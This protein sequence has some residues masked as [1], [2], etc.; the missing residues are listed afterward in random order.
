MTEPSIAMSAAWYA[1]QAVLG[2]AVSRPEMLGTGDALLNATEFADVQ[3][4]LL[5]NAIVE[6]QPA[7]DRPGGQAG[8]DLAPAAIGQV[9]NN[10][11][12]LGVEARRGISTDV[13]DLNQV[14]VEAVKAAPTNFYEIAVY[15]RIV[16]EAAGRR[17]LEVL[18]L[19]A[20]PSD[21]VTAADA[22]YSSPTA[23]EVADRKRA[24]SNMYK[25]ARPA[26]D[27]V[28]PTTPLPA[29]LVVRQERVL[30][31]AVLTDAKVR[32]QGLLEVFQPEDFTSGEHAT[33]WRFMQI[34]QEHDKLVTPITVAWAAEKV[35]PGELTVSQLTRLPREPPGGVVAATAVVARVAWMRCDALAKELPG[36]YARSGEAVV[37][38]RADSPLGTAAQPIGHE[39]RRGDVVQAPAASARH[40]QLP[41][42]QTTPSRDPAR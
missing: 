24:L 16:R 10:A 27:P 3:H 34:A 33:I 13:P 29:G 25:Q 19:R 37:R 17:V 35:S 8:L 20:A 41:A 11:A 18:D 39:A 38:T 2:A 26:A 15:H 36:S 28:A 23:Q 42:A 22:G 31:R 1:E 12:V 40:R 32:E 30:I 5:W 21:V 14:L 4:A 7:P 9:M 6:L